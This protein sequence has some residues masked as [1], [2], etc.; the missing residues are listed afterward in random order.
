M[1]TTVAPKLK[2]DAQI[3]RTKKYQALIAVGLSPEDAAKKYREIVEGA[4]PEPV[5]DPAADLLAAGF[6]QEE[7]DAIIGAG[8]TTPEPAEKVV[9]AKKTSQELGEALVENAGLAF[10]KGRVY[11]TPD[12]IEAAVRVRKTSSPEVVSSSGVGRTAAV[13]VFKTDGGDVAIQNLAKPTA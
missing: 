3:A 1:T 8:A 9:L 12:I 10:T 6:S 2:S 7:V 13:L 4:A 11:V 5:I